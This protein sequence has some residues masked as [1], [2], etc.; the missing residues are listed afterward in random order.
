MNA[1][2]KAMVAARAAGF[3]IPELE[4]GWRRTAW[5]AGSHNVTPDNAVL[6]ELFDWGY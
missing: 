3:Y 1:Y 2:L 6:A 4:C 5:D